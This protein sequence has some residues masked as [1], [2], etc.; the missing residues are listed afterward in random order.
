MFDHNFKTYKWNRWLSNKHFHFCV[1]KLFNNSKIIKTINPHFVK[2][3]SNNKN[4]VT[5]FRITAQ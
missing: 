1:V 2:D 3:Q 5:L 4:A